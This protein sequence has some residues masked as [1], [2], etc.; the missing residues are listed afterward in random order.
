MLA[1]LLA[2]AARAPRYVY[3]RLRRQPALA[4]A[5]GTGLAVL[6]LAIGAGSQRLFPP[7]LVIIGLLATAVSAP[8]VLGAGLLVAAGQA[9]PILTHDLSAVEERPLI[10]A[11]AA[12]VV[13]PLLFAFLLERLARFMLDMH[14]V[15]STAAPPHRR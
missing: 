3:E 6:H 13:T 11:A 10:A 1:C 12:D 9:A 7:S 4:V 15:I 14:R 2:A 5:A 8:W